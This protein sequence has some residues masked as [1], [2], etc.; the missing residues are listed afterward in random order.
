MNKSSLYWLLAPEGH[1]HSQI[2]CWSNRWDVSKFS[3]PLEQ[4]ITYLNLLQYISSIE[5]FHSILIH[6]FFTHFCLTFDC[7]RYSLKAI[8]LKNVS[9][10]LLFNFDHNCNQSNVNK[11]IN[12]CIKIVLDLESIWLLF[13]KRHK[14]GWMPS[15]WYCNYDTE[16]KV[17]IVCVAIK[18]K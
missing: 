18:W 14:I 7:F 9:K 3:L 8:C 1:L 6:N 5:R 13:W 12:N 16:Y 2:I 11:I 17:L 15:Q 4:L 10:N